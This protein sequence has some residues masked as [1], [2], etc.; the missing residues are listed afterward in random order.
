MFQSEIKSTTEELMT[1]LEILNLQ[2][3]KYLLMSMSFAMILHCSLS[4]ESK[5]RF[6]KVQFQIMISNPLKSYLP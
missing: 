1:I 3:L 6:I 4:L 2:Q 5:N